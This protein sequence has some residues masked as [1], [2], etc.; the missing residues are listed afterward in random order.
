MNKGNRHG[1]ARKHTTNFWQACNST[2]GNRSELSRSSLRV[3]MVN[4]NNFIA[5][6]Q[7]VITKKWPMLV[8]EWMLVKRALTMCYFP[9]L[10]MTFLR[11]IS[12]PRGK[13]SATLDRGKLPCSTR[14]SAQ[15]PMMTQRREA[16][17]CGRR[18]AHK[19]EGICII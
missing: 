12:I 10:N 15:C 13:N 4:I 6:I 2:S 1:Q 3:T 18:K 11:Q 8:I 19:R 16:G 9:F 14:S 7:Y 17:W 5:V